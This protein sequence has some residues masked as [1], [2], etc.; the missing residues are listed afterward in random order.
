MPFRGADG[1]GSQAPLRLKS[2]A[3]GS[4]CMVRFR[5]FLGWVDMTNTKYSN[6]GEAAYGF[7]HEALATAGDP[8][9]DAHAAD[10]GL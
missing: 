3:K 10:T 7:L 1:D 9:V 4:M 2:K 8:G 6:L 5:L